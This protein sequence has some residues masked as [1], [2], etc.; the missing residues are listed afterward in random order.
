MRLVQDA[1]ERYDVC[2]LDTDIALDGGKIR[3]SAGAPRVVGDDEERMLL[4]LRHIVEADPPLPVRI[5]VHHGPVFTGQVGPAYR[6]WYAVMGDT[7]NLAARLAAEAPAGHIYATREVLGRAKT[8]FEQTALEPFCVK[9]KSRHVE[10]ADVG[11]PVRAVEGAAVRL[12]PPLVGRER[13]MSQTESG[14]RRPPAAAAARCSSW[15][16]R[17]GAAN[18]GCSRKREDSP[19][20]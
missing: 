5:G 18:R 6:K 13:E 2:F 3:L 10:A 15:S 1:A 9:G 7:V 12:K 4:A 11:P 8:T 20:G 19:T 16:V 17:P 14:D